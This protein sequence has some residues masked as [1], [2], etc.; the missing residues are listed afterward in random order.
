[1]LGSI[2]LEE[3]EEI[4]RNMKYV[5]KLHQP[6]HVHL[7]TKIVQIEPLIGK[8]YRGPKWRW[9]RS[10]GIVAKLGK[11]IQSCMTPLYKA[12]GWRR[13]GASLRA[14]RVSWACSFRAIVGP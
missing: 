13:L 4:K 8:C 3:T 12:R 6:I 2:K 9:L 1:M 5:Y 11:Y 10:S 14:I 7:I